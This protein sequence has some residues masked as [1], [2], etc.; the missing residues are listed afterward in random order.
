MKH[1][2]SMVAHIWANQRTNGE[3]SAEGNGN[4]YFEGPTIYSYGR[5]FPIARHVEHKGRRAILF[6][7]QTNS[8]TTGKHI[9][10]VQHALQGTRTTII[11]LH[12]LDDSPA[13]VRK[14]FEHERNALVFDIAKSKRPAPAK[15]RALDEL[16]S[17][18]NAYAEFYGL[19]WRLAMP[20]DFEAE[21]KRAIARTER[22]AREQFK[23]ECVRAEARR[24]ELAEDIEAWKHAGLS[25]LPHDAGTFLRIEGEEIATSHGARVPVNAARK[26]FPIIKAVH[27]MARDRIFFSLKPRLGHFAIDRIDADGT[28][29][30][31]CHV[32]P[33]AEIE[34]IAGQ[35]GLIEPTAAFMPP[36][37]PAAASI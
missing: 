10:Y 5:H 11:N 24:L 32:I 16:I 3:T 25:Y 18:A 2:G 35:L 4:I 7:T 34:R 21:R 9:G 12:N 36:D 31:G 33:W 28:I 27:D 30:A 1:H 15:M 22:K 17:N 29:H 13:E 23:R 6:T 26:A 8:V 37:S 19:R 20:A 14:Q